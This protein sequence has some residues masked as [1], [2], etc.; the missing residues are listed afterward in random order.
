MKNL[1]LPSG[2]SLCVR[3]FIASLLDESMA[4]ITQEIQ[5]LPSALVT[6]KNDSLGDD[7]RRMPA[8]LWAGV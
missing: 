8:D 2:M 7:G 5:E 6:A 3:I 4:T 1:E